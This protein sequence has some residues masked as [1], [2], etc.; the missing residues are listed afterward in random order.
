MNQSAENDSGLQ[1]EA[2]AFLE[3]DF[4]QCF[5]QMRHYDA[6]IFDIVKF[7]FTAYSALIGVALALYKFGAKEGVDLTLPVIAALV[8]G[9]L[10]G[11]FMFSLGIRNRVYFVLVARYINEQRG[12]FL[13]YKPL[14]FQNKCR[15][16]T[17]H[18][19]PPYYN[20]R[21]SQ[22][23]LT[24][25]IACLNSAILGI[26]LF[27]MIGPIHCKWKVIWTSSITLFVLQLVFGIVYL[28]SR[29]NKSSSRAVFGK[30]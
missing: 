21:S 29:Q 12:V 24:Y 26:L 13:R 27:F 5:A 6:Q 4:N 11:L 25:I 9:L 28:T 19:Q 14:G 7:A 16:Y 17:N 22:A 18:S 23:W 30:G 10:L 20:W 8:I 2:A 3:A 1:K 15:M